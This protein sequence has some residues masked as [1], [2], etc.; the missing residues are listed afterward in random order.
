[1]LHDARLFTTTLSWS[2]RSSNKWEPKMPRCTSPTNHIFPGTVPRPNL[3]RSPWGF[4]RP[5]EAYGRYLTGQV[6]WPHK[7]EHGHG[8]F[9]LCM[10]TLTDNA[11]TPQVGH[12]AT[13]GPSGLG[14][15]DMPEHLYH[16]T[17]PCISI[18]HITFA[19]HSWCRVS[20]PAG[21]L[22]PHSTQSGPKIA[23]VLCFAKH[24]TSIQRI[25]QHPP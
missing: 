8:V 23:S 13:P 17:H 1:M 15:K 6:R 10:L 16:E 14:S 24:P 12:E 11:Q 5:F 3:V 22:D 20:T 21:S 19:T 2:A 7:R 18:P 25:S 9:A 4:T